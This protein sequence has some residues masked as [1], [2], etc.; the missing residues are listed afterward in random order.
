MVESGEFLP[1]KMRCSDEPTR[2]AN[3][4]MLQRLGSVTR[5]LMIGIADEDCTKVVDNAADPMA[6]PDVSMS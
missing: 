4:P 6:N 3:G 1:L 2:V 5:L